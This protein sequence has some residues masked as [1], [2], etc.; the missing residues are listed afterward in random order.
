MGLWT[1]PAG[2]G[3]G[4]GRQVGRYPKSH[5]GGQEKKNRLGARG[6]AGAEKKGEIDEEETTPHGHE[7][8]E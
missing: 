5:G 1:P 6:D 3:P 7:K 4:E 8:C 2:F